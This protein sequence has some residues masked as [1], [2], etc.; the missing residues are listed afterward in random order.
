LVDGAQA[1]VSK[2]VPAPRAEDRDLA[3]AT[4]QDIFLSHGV[5]ATADMGTSIEDWQAMRRAG[6]NGT[7]K[8]RVMAYGD[9]IANMALIGG[10]GPTPWLYD[11]KLRLNGVKLYLDGALGS[12]GASLKAPYADAATKGL[13]FLTETQLKNLMSRAAMD[14]FQIA[15]HAIGDAA[16]A[17]VLSAVE[18]LAQT[19]KGDRRWRIEHA[20]I[21]D[22]ADL[23][24]FGQNGV[25]AS[26]QPVHQTSDRQMAEA[27]LGPQRLAGSYAWASMLKNGA[28]LAFG[29][30]AP[31]ER[32]DP[33]DGIAAAISRVDSAGEPQGGWQ[34]QEVVTREQALAAYTSGAA[35]AGF[36]EGRFG[37]LTLGQRADFVLVDTDP[38]KATP[39]AIRKTKVLQSWVGGKLMWQTK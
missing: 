9:G 38:L 30:D 29:S 36:A 33:F 26:M 3:F 7:L 10:S 6:D 5:T 34:A 1:L 16:N 20:Q 24:R 19:Y 23:P 18:D 35:Y 25:I 22:P 17:M 12:R 28:K 37:R 13:P 27:R 39:Q 11:D 31:V 8:I 32:A 14:H 15:V 2:I 21:V 4:A